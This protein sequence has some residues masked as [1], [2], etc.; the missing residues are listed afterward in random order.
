M[1]VC[2]WLCWIY[3]VSLHR[4]LAGALF[5]DRAWCVCVCVCVCVCACVCSGNTAATDHYMT[6]IM[7]SVNSRCKYPR[8]RIEP[9]GKHVHFTTTHTHTLRH[10]D[11]QTLSNASNPIVAINHSIFL[12]PDWYMCVC[13][14]D[15]YVYGGTVSLL[16]T[17]WASHQVSY[18]RGWTTKDQTQ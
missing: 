8:K 7:S 17:I 1:C 6:L 15:Q 18:S 10:S 12:P 13:V 16:F 11:S 14:W 2:V 4:L 5:T 3:V 9:R